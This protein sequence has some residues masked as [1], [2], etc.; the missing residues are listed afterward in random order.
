[1][2]IQKYLGKIYSIKMQTPCSDKK[3]ETKRLLLILESGKNLSLHARFQN[4]IIYNSLIKFQDKHLE[5]KDLLKLQKRLPI[6]YPWNPNYDSLREIVNRRFN[7]YPLGIVMA[8]KASDIQKTVLFCQSKGIPMGIRSGGHCFEGF[9]INDGIVIDQSSR[10]EVQLNLKTNQVRV[11]PGCL[12]GPTA[13]KISSYGLALPAGTNPSV[14]CVGLALGGG[15]GFLSRKFGLTTDNILEAKIILADG[16]KVKANEK[17]NPDLFWATRGGGG[18]NFGIVTELILQLHVL[19]EVF[20]YEITYDFSQF[21]SALK[22]WQEWSYQITENLA[23]EFHCY[24][25]GSQ[26]SISG[27]CFPGDDNINILYQL[28]SPVL[29]IPHLQKVAK[30][31][32]YL[33][34]VKRW[35][36]NGHWKN[37]F[38]S[39]N[40]FIKNLF[41]DSALDIMIKYISQGSG[42]DIFELTS[43]GGAVDTPESTAAFAHRGYRSWMMI[44]THWDCVDQE[45]KEIEWSRNFYRELSPYLAD[46]VYVNGPDRDLENPM[47][48]YY[49]SNLPRLKEIKKRYNPSNSFNF[50]HA[51]PID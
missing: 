2:E 8:Q 45:K 43:L 36:G 25:K 34:A 11:Q 30:R 9:C 3:E 51:I 24:N 5:I 18:S 26:V 46:A 27:E 6:T 50:A 47:F 16:S 32:P 38:K 42:N 20:I 4:D 10:T 40:A 23:S 14:G 29:Q 39:K 21:K 49:G 37:Y 13:E 7:I 35:G 48:K 41:P 1:M 19:P 33:E 15:I 31:V 28:L 17:E 12:L 44:N 22:V